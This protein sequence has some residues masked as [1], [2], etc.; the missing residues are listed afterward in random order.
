M[1]DKIENYVKVFELRG[2]A[3]C[4]DSSFEQ[5]FEKLAI[6]QEDDSS[7]TH[8]ARQLPNGLWLSK[9]GPYEDVQH[10]TPEALTDDDYGFPSIYLRRR[11]TLWIRILRQIKSRWCKSEI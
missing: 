4:P 9:L 6:Y 7:F 10:K 5:G 3:V 11:M 1:V 2:Y 8:I